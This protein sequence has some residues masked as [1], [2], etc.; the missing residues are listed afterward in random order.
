MSDRVKIKPIAPELVQSSPTTKSYRRRA[1]PWA[2]VGVVA[3]VLV[4]SLVMRYLPE[5]ITYEGIA[6]DQAPDVNQETDPNAPLPFRDVKLER[7]EAAARE[8]LATFGAL[9]DRV[10]F[11][12]LGLETYRADYDA[13]IDMANAADA[14]FAKREFDDAI[15]QYRAA[16]DALLTYV[17]RQ[18]DSFEQNL[19]AGIAAIA[20]RNVN[21]AKTSL[22]VAATHRPN[23]P[24]LSQAQDRLANLPETNRLIREAQ[25]AILRND[26]AAAESFLVKADE[27]DPF[28]EDIEKQLQDLRRLRGD[29]EYNELITSGYAALNSGQLDEAKRIFENALGKRPNDSGAKTG[30][31]EVL[32]RSDNDAIATLKA[33]AERQE[34][35][36]NL[37]AAMQTY[38]TV[39]ELEPNLQFALDG[40]ERNRETVSLLAA[41]ERILA[42][43]D[44]L[45]SNKEFENAQEILNDARSHEPMQDRHASKIDRLSHLLETASKPLPIVL[46][47]DRSMQVRLATV[48]ELEPFDR[49][50]LTLR[51][52]RYLITGSA[53]GCRDVRKTIVVAEGM[54]PVAIVC[55]EPI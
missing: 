45:S 39:L 27:L 6:F 54:A 11:E 13:I 46:V 17:Q 23:E 3:I 8:I 40:F 28:T 53:N 5:Q 30:L 48:G 52:G 31:N 9:Q 32:K 24:A 14:A 55:D 21:R 41:V 33:R 35:A 43:P 19:N 12:R 22:A 10:E 51:P 18:E 36:E 20:N 7:S 1:V 2:L 34:R 16:T 50:E 38:S 29:E 47:S 4:A 42:D 49:K 44:M 15:A 37:R 25:R 26:Y